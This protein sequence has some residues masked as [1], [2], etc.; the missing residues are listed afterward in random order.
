MCKSNYP[1]LSSIRAFNFKI[2]PKF[3]NF[4]G[5]PA[6]QNKEMCRKLV[7][8]KMTRKLVIPLLKASLCQEDKTICTMRN[9][10]LISKKAPKQSSE[11]PHIS[12]RKHF[13]KILTK[14][15]LSKMN[16]G[17]IQKKIMIIFKAEK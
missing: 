6:N 12:D 4:I 15:S 14:I 5:K 1:V 9:L 8:I 7:Q 11:R 13:L 3:F 10:T 2:S 16:P 17:E